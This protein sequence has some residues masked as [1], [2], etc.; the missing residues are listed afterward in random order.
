MRRAERCAVKSDPPFLESSLPVGVLRNDDVQ[1]VG[2]G[3]H[4]SV[5]ELVVQ[6]AE[7]KAVEFL[8]RPAGLPSVLGIRRLRYDLA[9]P[10]FDDA[11]SRRHHR[12]KIWGSDFYVTTF[13]PSIST[14]QGI[15]IVTD[16]TLYPCSS[17]ITR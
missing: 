9:S 8:V 6:S 3:E 4:T 14:M 15:P 2:E 1:L 17:M 7:S 13:H 16:F 11:R 10:D 5:E 12:E